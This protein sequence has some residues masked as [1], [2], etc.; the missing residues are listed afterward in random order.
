MKIT[1]PGGIAI[2]VTGDEIP[3]ALSAL[4]AAMTMDGETFVADLPD[5]PGEV[6][7]TK[8]LAPVFT[9]LQRQ[10]GGSTIREI[11]ASL[12]IDDKLVSNSLYRLRTPI[13]L[14]SKMDAEGRYHLTEAGRRARM[15]IAPPRAAMDLNRQLGWL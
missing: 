10:P 12:K 7:L 8:T 6:Y 14:V 5:S 9:A 15:R 11:A 13:E 3:M 2:E 1:L 4:A